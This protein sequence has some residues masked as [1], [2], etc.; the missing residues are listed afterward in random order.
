[1]FWLSILSWAAIAV[2]IEVFVA[3][4]FNVVYTR[5]VGMVTSA[6]FAVGYLAGKY[7]LYS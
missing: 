2:L 4:I 1:M 5:G 3:L 7:P 6:A